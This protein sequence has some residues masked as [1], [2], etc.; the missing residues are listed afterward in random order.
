MM[1][2]TSTYDPAEADRRIWAQMLEIR[3]QLLKFHVLRVCE[4][5]EIESL[6]P[7][8]AQR[9]FFGAILRSRRLSLSMLYPGQRE[10]FLIEARIIYDL[11]DD[12]DA[13]AEYLKQ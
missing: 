13:L 5:I 12:P 11:H 2:T 3:R 4:E 7:A 8:A 10:E 1:T 6:S 9:R